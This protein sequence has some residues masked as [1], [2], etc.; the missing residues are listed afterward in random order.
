VAE[1]LAGVALVEAGVASA[2]AVVA[3]SRAAAV[4]RR[5]DLLVRGLDLDLTDRL[6][7]SAAVKELAADPARKLDAIRT[8]REETGTDLAT[9]KAAVELYLASR[10][11]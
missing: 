11:P 3:L 10:K 5:F 9:A 8:Y 6:N 7:L 2:V 4:Q 1:V